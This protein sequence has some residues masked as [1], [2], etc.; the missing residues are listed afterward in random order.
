MKK[1]IFWLFKFSVCIILLAVA[2]SIC[3]AKGLPVFELNEY[4]VVGWILQICFI[5]ICLFISFLNW[6]IGDFE[7]R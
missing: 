4:T 3:E 1:I 7:K 5:I 6:G 2:E